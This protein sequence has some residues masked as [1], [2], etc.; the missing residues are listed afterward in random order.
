MPNIT[1]KKQTIEQKHYF[2]FFWI[3]TTFNRVHLNCNHSVSSRFQQI[4]DAKTHHFGRL[5]QKSNRKKQQQPNQ[6]I[7]ADCLY[8]ASK[9]CNMVVFSKFFFHELNAQ[10]SNGN[11]GNTWIYIWNFFF[12]LFVLQKTHTHISYST[13]NA[14]Y[15]SHKYINSQQ[16]TLDTG[17][18]FRAR[19]YG[20]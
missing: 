3:F 9:I 20:F 11:E 15:A 5:K 14:T 17:H 4:F 7:D 2:T 18:S 16:F 13:L 19:S 6:I 12:L 8:P 1:K 10:N